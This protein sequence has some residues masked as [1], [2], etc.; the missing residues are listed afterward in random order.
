M[1]EYITFKATLRSCQRGGKMRK[2][3]KK[4]HKKSKNQDSKI[5]VAIC[6]REVGEEELIGQWVEAS[7]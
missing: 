1:S 7:I 4:K 5:K 3:E 6:R 2:E